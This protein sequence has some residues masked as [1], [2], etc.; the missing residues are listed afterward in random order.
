MKRIV[1]SVQSLSDRAAALSA[2]A[3]QLPGRVAEIRQSVAATTGQLQH[4]KTDIQFNVAELQVTS[5]NQL[6]TALMEID[7]NAKVLEDAGFE[8]EGVD[9]ELSPSQRLV[10]HLLRIGDA[11]DDEFRELIQKHQGL[12]TIRAILASLLKA[13]N[14][15]ATIEIGGLDYHRVLIGI[16]ASPVVRLCWR[17]PVAAASSLTMAAAPAIAPAGASFFGGGESLFATAAAPAPEPPTEPPPLPAAA[18]IPEPSTGPPQL[19]PPAPEP[20][21]ESAP[22]APPPLPEPTDPLARFKVMPTLHKP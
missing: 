19:P 11:D 9:L 21:P 6:A 17:A 5:E 16:G 3:G 4:L 2:A 18:Q 1:R 8:L 14:M 13:R 20:E 22:E 12:P 15:A 10:V 7:N